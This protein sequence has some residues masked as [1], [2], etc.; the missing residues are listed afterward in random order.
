MVVGFQDIEGLAG[1]YGEKEAAE[2]TGLCAN[3]AFL[4]M[5][6]PKTAQWAS[7]IL[8]ERE[9]L[10]QRYSEN[11]SEGEAHHPGSFSIFGAKSTNA[12]KS[13]GLSEHLVKRELVLP[14]E[15]LSMPPTTRENGLTGYYLTP[16]LGAYKV[17]ILPEHLTQ[18]LVPPNTNVPNVI[19]RPETD[20]YLRPW[21]AQDYGRLRV[22]EV[23]E[24]AVPDFADSAQEQNMENGAVMQEGNV[25]R[26]IRRK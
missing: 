16:L 20:Q 26:E 18:W 11:E 25:L 12:S 3:K 1:I 8:G 22:S 15:F 14:S 7:S 13:K 17:H 4:R 10:E 9:V 21:D 19:S 2:I 24:I 6:S 23:G 5:D